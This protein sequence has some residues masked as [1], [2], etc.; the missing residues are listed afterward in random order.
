MVSG[1]VILSSSVILKN[2]SI[3][4]LDEKTIAV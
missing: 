4:V 1:M 3:A 2:A